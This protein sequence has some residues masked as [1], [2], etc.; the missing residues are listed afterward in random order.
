MAAILRVALC[1]LLSLAAV[2][3]I[4][5]PDTYYAKGSIQLPYAGIVEPYETWMDG[6]GRVSR[7]DYYGGIG[8]MAAAVACMI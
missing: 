3:A 4:T 8:K 5:L 7:I 6:R 1:I 2:R